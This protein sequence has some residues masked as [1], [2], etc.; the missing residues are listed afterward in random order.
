[1]WDERNSAGIHY[2]MGSCEGRGVAEILV[3][4]ERRAIRIE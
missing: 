2:R 4:S 3:Q 1:M